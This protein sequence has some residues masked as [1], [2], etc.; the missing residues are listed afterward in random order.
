MPKLAAVIYLIR[1]DTTFSKAVDGKNILWATFVLHIQRLWCR[2]R[3]NV[4]MRPRFEDKVLGALVEGCVPSGN[5]T[6]LN[7]FGICS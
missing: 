6:V 5:T 2:Y 1:V 4:V 7:S 3:D